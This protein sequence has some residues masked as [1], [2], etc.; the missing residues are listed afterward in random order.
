MPPQPASRLLGV[1][2]MPEYFQTEGI[3]AVLDRLQKAGV[4]AITTSPYVMERADEKSGGREPPDDAGAGSVR[5]LD[6]PLWGQR[7]LFVRTAPSF[8]PD[9]SLYK[10]LRYQPTPPSD[11]TRAQGK[12][13][14]EALKAAQARHIKTYL[15]VQAAIPPGYRVQFGGPIEDDIPLLPTGQPPSR[16]LAKNGSLASP[17]IQEYLAA[18]LTDLVRNYPGVDGIRIDWP[19]Y[20][21]YFLDDLF[22]DFSP[23]VERFARQAGIPFKFVQSQV[24]KLYRTVHGGLT[25]A[26][27]EAW[28]SADGGRS[29]LLALLTR[30]PLLAEFVRLKSDMAAEV[31]KVARQALDKADAKRVELLPNA[32]PPPFSILSGFDFGR[33]T[34]TRCAGACVKLYSMHWAM[35]L[36]FYADVLT[37]A[38][39]SLD[40]TLL[41][42]VLVRLF[43]M[44][45]D[46]GLPKLEDYRYPESHEPH[47]ASSASLA[48]K[49]TQARH[50]AGKAPIYALAHGYGPLDDFRR[51]LQA[52]WD[53]SPDGVWINRYA[54][55]SDAKFDAVRSVCR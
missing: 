15:Q 18:L 21:P 31:W 25:N 17:H 47:P 27:L 43:D 12:I 3:D 6:R 49:I 45:D 55:L 46:D 28:L 23:H 52:T 5:L 33:L 4:T 34:E 44:A 30:Q 10:G 24:L 36:R 39:P 7:E 13:V 37:K 1:T 48:R 16:R 19:E 11:L 14:A 32:F 9:V 41:K 51:R 26:D 20:P 53:A 42:R 40:R 38:N 8:T 29:A 2:V 35:M 54:Y 50:L 22:L